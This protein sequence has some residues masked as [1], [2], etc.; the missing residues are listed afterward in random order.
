[1]QILTIVL[2]GKELGTS[3]LAQL[4]GLVSCLRYVCK[5]QIGPDDNCGPSLSSMAV[6]QNFV[7][8][9][10]PSLNNDVVHYLAYIDSGF[11]GWSR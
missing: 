10:W 7:F 2:V 5:E 9:I 6:D 3:R 11:V 4:N 8:S 1:M